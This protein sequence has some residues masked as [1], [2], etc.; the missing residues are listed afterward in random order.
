MA[1]MHLRNQSYHHAI[2]IYGWRLV[3]HST[4][5][6]RRF[7][8]CPNR[9][10]HLTCTYTA[11]APA[12]IIFCHNNMHSEWSFLENS[13][14]YAVEKSFRTGRNKRRYISG[15]LDFVQSERIRQFTYFNI[16][17][18]P[19]NQSFRSLGLRLFTHLEIIGFLKYSCIQNV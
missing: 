5:R 14:F 12:A 8:P 18:S 10:P 4:F 2:R 17:L 15:P 6:F 3:D 16:S 11:R 9:E 13:T 19:I 1:A 7:F